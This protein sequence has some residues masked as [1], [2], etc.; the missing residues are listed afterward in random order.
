MALARGILFAND[1]MVRCD[2][3]CKLERFWQVI[4]LP[5]PLIP[6][7][8]FLNFT[9]VAD[10]TVWVFGKMSKHIV[11]VAYL[12]GFKPRFHLGIG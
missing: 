7:S 3:I 1:L 11:F 12:L 10:V 4:G 6:A 9:R 8:C 2:A 5:V